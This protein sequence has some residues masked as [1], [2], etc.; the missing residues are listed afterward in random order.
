MHRRRRTLPS[1]R[2]LCR[3]RP[4]IGGAGRFRLLDACADL[5]RASAALD[6][7]VVDLKPKLEKRAPPGPVRRCHRSVRSVHVFFAGA[8]L[9]VI[10]RRRRSRDQ[11][12]GREDSEPRGSWPCFDRDLDPP[13]LS[14]NALRVSLENFEPPRRP[15]RSIRTGTGVLADCMAGRRGAD[16]RAVRLEIAER[17]CRPVRCG[18]RGVPGRGWWSAGGSFP[19]RT[20]SARSLLG[21]RFLGVLGERPRRG[22]YRRRRLRRGRCVSGRGG[23]SWPTCEL[24]EDGRADGADQADEDPARARP[25]LFTRTSQRIEGEVHR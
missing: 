18:G 8:M 1:S 21:D 19:R 9:P 22:R 16:A 6:A 17:S 4:C 13:R 7:S 24:P 10:S 3:P 14:R 20:T 11:Q 25:Q 12:G 2:R 15:V 5:A 23:R